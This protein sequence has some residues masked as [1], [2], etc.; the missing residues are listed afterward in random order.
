MFLP[1]LVIEGF[2]LGGVFMKNTANT[3]RTLCEIGIFAALGFVFDELQGVLFGGVFPNGGSIGFAMIAVLIIAYRRGLLPALLTGL[4]MGLFDIATK[5]Y[6]IHPLQVLLDYIFPYFLVGFAGLLKPLFD[7]SNTKQE[8]VLWLIAGTFLGG[9]LKLASHY[10]AGVIYWADPTYFAWNLNEM[11]PYLYC[12]I[13][14]IA[15][16]GPSIIL[17]GALLVVVYLTAPKVLTNKPFVEERERENKNNVPAIASVGLIAVGA[18]LFVYFF[19][20]WINSFYYKSSSQKYYFNQDSMVIYVLGIAFIIL[21]VICLIS[22]FKNKFNYLVMSS[23]LFAITGISLVYGLAKLIESFI[24]EAPTNT[25]LIWTIVAFVGFL[26]ALV[27]F[28]FSLKNSQ[29]ERA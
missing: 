14:N 25:Y 11:N 8:K 5:A 7:N 2:I 9:L 12:F 23:S 13:Y 20:K 19:I 15:F 4:L 22:Y 24:D 21:G 3:I 17:T 26:G 29:K 18:F 16:I 1:R 6:V 10:F 28:I 27:F